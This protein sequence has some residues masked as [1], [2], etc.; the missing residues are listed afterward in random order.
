MDPVTKNRFLPLLILFVVSIFVVPLSVAVNL[1]STFQPAD[2]AG[3]SSFVC[4][5]GSTSRLVCKTNPESR[6]PDCAWRCQ[7]L[8]EPVSEVIPPVT[9]PT[10]V[11]CTEIENCPLDCITVSDGQGCDVCRCDVR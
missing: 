11:N 9:A 10:A 5:D 1:N 6:Q 3:L 2:A 8:P 4:A 7:F